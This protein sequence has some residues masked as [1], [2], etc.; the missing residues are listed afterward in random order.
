M[1]RQ[2]L[3]EYKQEL[4]KAGQA[5]LDK[6]MPELTEELFSMYEKTGNRI[7][8]ENVYFGRRK[9]LSVFGVLAML[10]D[11][12]ED[13]E[14]LE[15]VI[16]AVCEEEC[17]ALPAHVDRQGDECW[18]LT[19]DLF[20]AET[21]F[22]LAEIISKL[23]E[24]LS[25]QVYKR[26]KEEVFRRVLTP[27]LETK[28]NH[29]WWENCDM[30]WCAVCNGSIGSAAIWLIKDTEI[31]HPLLQRICAGLTHYIEGFTE[32]GA[33]LEGMRYYTYGMGFYVGFA[34]L[35]RSYTKGEMDLLK[36]PKLKKIA[37]FQQVCFLPGGGTVCFADGDR[38]DTFR[39]GMTLYLA[40]QYPEMRIPDMGAA[41]GWDSD[42]C[43]RYMMISRD[44]FFTEAYLA[45]LE[46]A[47]CAQANIGNR[48]VG[49]SWLKDAQWCVCNSRNGAVLAC[50]GGHN[51][52]P[53]NHNDVGSFFY[54]ADGVMVLADLGAGEYT[55]EY[56]G[57]KRYEQLC[58]RSLGHNL[59][60][61]DGME[62]LPGRE[63]R[64]TEFSSD[65]EGEILIGLEAA[66]NL[67]ENELVRRKYKFDMEEGTVI[68]EDS[69]SFCKERRVTENLVTTYPPQIRDDGFSIPTKGGIYEIFCD[70]GEN[71]R[72][73]QEEYHNHE[74]IVEK[75][76]LMQWDVK[77]TITRFAIVPQSEVHV[78]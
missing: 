75:V 27:F 46:Q 31:L 71:Y 17:W 4:R 35:L 55:R 3:D 68:V 40:M 49:Q 32:D 48:N 63:R 2:F 54:M 76:W 44:I 9:M 36:A 77:G 20:A 67:A 39:M 51:E 41:A 47:E 1:I 38:S 19:I 42:N 26:A 73:L 8:Y 61:I 56:F 22:Y 25:S 52:E 69:F 30:N 29:F 7:A 60:L 6:P 18:Q 10:D 59:P 24:R 23:K 62:Q 34:D 50:K 14:K 11:R 43:Y 72:I 78:S 57:E 13:I 16:T 66:Y 21:A 70:G 5:L 12:K 53:H 74:G 58:C 65:T 37:L 28:A 15:E 64:A 45:R 33:C